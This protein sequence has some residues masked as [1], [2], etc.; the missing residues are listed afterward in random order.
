M[1]GGILFA[2]GGWFPDTFGVGTQLIDAG[3]ET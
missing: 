1:I 2:A 3:C